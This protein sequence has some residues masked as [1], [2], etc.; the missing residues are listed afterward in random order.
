M[1]G[2]QTIVAKLPSEQIAN[3]E[4]R[5]GRSRACFVG[6]VGAGRERDSLANW[7]ALPFEADG[8]AFRVRHGE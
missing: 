1:V 7:L 3:E 6:L 8:A 4:Y 2:E 5:K